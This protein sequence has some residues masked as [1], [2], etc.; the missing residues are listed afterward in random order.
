MDGV[1]S[2]RKTG[3]SDLPECLALHPAKNGAE[4]V[5]KA[6]VLKAWHQLFQTTYA[7][8]S[9]VVELT[10]KGHVEIVGFGFASF[11]KKSFAEAEVK[12][13]RPG[14]NARIIESI[15]A[16][17]SVAAT[18]EEVRDA[19]TRGDLEQ[20]VLDTSWHRHLDAKQVDEVLFLLARAYQHLFAGY[21]FSRILN[22]MVDELDFMSLR[23]SRA[24]GH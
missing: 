18:F 14:L 23:V 13:A 5:G 21:R 22:E 9:A 6:H 1:F 4:M 3:A 19:N 20:V 16:G 2:W 17:N 24:F 10:T 8:R 15:I 11:V 12:N 7:T